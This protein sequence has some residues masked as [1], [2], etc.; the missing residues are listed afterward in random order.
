MGPEE[1]RDGGRPGVRDPESR[2]RTHLANE[3]TF[4][5][6]LRT[7]LSLIAL[8]LAADQFLAAHPLPVL[9][10]T[11]SLA[12]ILVLGGIVLTVAGAAQYRRGRERIEAGTYEPDTRVAVI[13]TALII[14]V[15][16]LAL[17]FIFLRS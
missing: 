17:A 7:G 8:G 10:I 9:P 6:W 2:A 12:T 14:V 13:S 16:L 4:L 1:T 5:A 3:R 11:P 15:G